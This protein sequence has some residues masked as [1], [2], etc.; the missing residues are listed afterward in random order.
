MF[1]DIASVSFE[2]TYYSVVGLIFSWSSLLT[3]KSN[4]TSRMARR[5]GVKNDCLS[6]LLRFLGVSDDPTHISDVVLVA[7][8]FENVQSIWRN[9]F[10]EEGCQVGVAVLDTRQLEK[11]RLAAASSCTD[12][13]LED[14]YSKEE[15]IKTYNFVTGPA[16][17][18][19]RTRIRNSFLFGKTV[20]I[21][22]N[23][24]RETIE[25]CIPQNREIIVVGHGLDNDLKALKTLKVKLEAYSLGHSIDTLIV[26]RQMFPPNC[27][28]KLR[29]VLRTLRC[30]YMGLH[31]AGNDAN[32]T[33]RAM[34]LLAARACQETHRETSVF[35]ATTA[36][37]SSHYIGQREHAKVKERELRRKEKEE[38][39]ES[40]EYLR[41]V[42][43][44]ARARR[45]VTAEVHNEQDFL[46]EGDLP[47]LE[48]FCHDYERSAVAKLQNED[49]V[50]R[51]GDLH[52]VETPW[53]GQNRDYAARPW[54]LQWIMMHDQA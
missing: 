53:H 2:L 16:K 45:D 24:M 48:T 35:L 14:A 52:W 54:G 7:I 26:S 15:V 43:S 1:L 31:C 9:E 25:S 47:R 44:I 41:G 37:T 3:I 38:F 12:H 23:E 27:S 46:E 39:K 34:L 5:K 19:E 49:D 32:F 22:S 29:G 50:L 21:N 42:K 13:E 20:F 17:Y 28:H 11:I 6:R 40:R 4:Q 36:T 8:D 51:E 33:L 18:C 10:S 30:P